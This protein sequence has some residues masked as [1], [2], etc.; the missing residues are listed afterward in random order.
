MLLMHNIESGHLKLIS[1]FF[2][3]LL[4]SLL[5]VLVI[6]FILIWGLQFL[7]NLFDDL[8][9]LI[10]ISSFLIVNEQ[11]WIKSK[12]LSTCS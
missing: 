6:F 11:G 8:F 4:F 12:E 10:F 1:F 7:F 9:L 5:F 2:L 3:S